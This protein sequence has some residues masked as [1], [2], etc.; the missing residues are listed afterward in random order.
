MRAFLPYLVNWLVLCCGFVAGAAWCGAHA[1]R[2][3]LEARELHVRE[4]LELPPP[5]LELRAA[6]RRRWRASWGARCWN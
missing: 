6:R 3:E 2:R 4:L 1:H 5:E